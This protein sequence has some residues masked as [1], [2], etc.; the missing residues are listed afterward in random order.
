MKF[1]PCL[2]ENFT[3]FCTIVFLL[4]Q[5]DKVAKKPAGQKNDVMKKPVSTGQFIKDNFAKTEKADEG[6][7]KSKIGDGAAGK[8][9]SLCCGVDVH[10]KIITCLGADVVGEVAIAKL[11]SFSMRGF[12]W[13]LEKRLAN[14]L[15]P[16]AGLG[17]SDLTLPNANTNSHHLIYCE[18]EF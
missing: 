5:E 18:S 15:G 17:V 13:T 11:G 1:S 16:I 10:A 6:D 8:D 12:L 9:L 14:A 7:D 4:L 2:G 3:C